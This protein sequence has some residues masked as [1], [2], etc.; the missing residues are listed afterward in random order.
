MRV[1]KLHQVAAKK[2]SLEQDAPL[3]QVPLE[4]Y[5]EALTS[6]TLFERPQHRRPILLIVGASFL[7]KSLLAAQVLEL[8]AAS[9]HLEGFV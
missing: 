9:L 7:G 5:P 4:P 6:T 1:R 3:Q 8:I 2:G